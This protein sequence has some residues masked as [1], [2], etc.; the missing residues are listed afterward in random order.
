MGLY[1]RTPLNAIQ[2]AVLRAI[3]RAILPAIDR[4]QPVPALDSEIDAQKHDLNEPRSGQQNQAGGTEPAQEPVRSSGGP[5]VAIAHRHRHRVL[6]VGPDGRATFTLTSE[7]K[8]EK[9]PCAISPR[10]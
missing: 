5:R 6:P 9:P 7:T 1:P 3:L 2:R 8:L 4:W 10:P